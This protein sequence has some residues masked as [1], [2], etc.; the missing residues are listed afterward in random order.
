M[1]Q[2][3]VKKWDKLSA[4][5]IFTS[6]G[7]AFLNGGQ[8]FLRTKRGNHNSYNTSNSNS[9][10][11]NGINLSFKETYSDVYNVYKGLIALRKANPEAFGANEAAKTSSISVG[12]TKYTTG[13]FL[14]YFNATDKAAAIDTK[15]YSKVVDVTTG[16]V[17]ESETLPTSVARKDFV[18]LKK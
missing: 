4:A 11:T 13:D 10:S 18:I 7:T 17:T 6:Q 15:G 12:V 16:V 5:Y 2:S 9:Y 3:E 14:I 8:E 1:Y